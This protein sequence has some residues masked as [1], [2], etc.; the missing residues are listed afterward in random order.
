[1]LFIKFTLILIAS[2]LHRLVMTMKTDVLGHGVTKCIHILK[3]GKNK[4]K[5][6]HHFLPKKKFR[7]E[8]NS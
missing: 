6:F 8:E 5:I 3:V 7:V 1:M 4:V 2:D